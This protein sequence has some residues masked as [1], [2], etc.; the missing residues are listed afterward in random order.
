MTFDRW[1][2]KQVKWN[3]AVLAEWEGKYIFMCM[4]GVAARSKQEIPKD[5]M[6]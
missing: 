4:E 6:F 1:R 2:G 3:A 5:G